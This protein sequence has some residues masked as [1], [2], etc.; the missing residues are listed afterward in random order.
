VFKPSELTPTTGALLADCWLETNLPA[1]VLNLVQGDRTTA[2]CLLD[3]PN[4]AG[5]LFTGSASTGRAIHARFG[6]R[7]EILLALEMGGNNALVLLRNTDPAAAARTIAVSAFLTAGQRC[8]CTRRL[9]LVDDEILAELVTVARALRVGRW[10]DE[11]PPF[12]GPVINKQAADR[13]LLAQQR[14]VDAG[15]TALEPCQAN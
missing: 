5:V 10:F 6:G 4:L 15:A 2:E 3:F 7:P 8:T 13:L 11:P 9:I 12:C 14:L 1:G